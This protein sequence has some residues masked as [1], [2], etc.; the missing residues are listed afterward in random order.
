MSD[1]LREEVVEALSTHFSTSM[2]A[3]MAAISIL[4]IIERERVKAAEDMRERAADEADEF[5]A[6]VVGDA[7]RALSTGEQE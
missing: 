2:A 4:P 1:T 6:D 3:G 7:I 5:G